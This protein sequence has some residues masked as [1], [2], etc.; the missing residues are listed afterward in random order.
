MSFFNNPKKQTRSA[1]VHTCG[2]Y[3][4]KNALS[5]SSKICKREC[6]PWVPRNMLPIIKYIYN[7]DPPKQ[8]TNLFPANT[9]G[10]GTNGNFLYNTWSFTPKV[11]GDVYVY[12]SWNYYTQND[13]ES[14]TSINLCTDKNVK[15][16]I[17]GQD[18]SGVYDLSGT[19]IIFTEISTDYDIYFSYED[20][21]TGR[22]I[23]LQNLDSSTKYCITAKTKWDNDRTDGEMD[24]GIVL[25][26]SCSN[27]LSINFKDLEIKE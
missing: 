27:F 26:D 16:D 20:F 23:I 19:E 24:I 10:T 25:V 11:S 3:T 13:T 12:L 5:K 2:N 9:E 1:F 18:V 6:T 4:T 21:N 14:I 22:N 15:V 8:F 17:S 7:E